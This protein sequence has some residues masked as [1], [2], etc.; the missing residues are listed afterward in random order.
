MGGGEKL[1]RKE[2]D[3]G[4]AKE[5]EKKCEAKVYDD[6]NDEV[7]RKLISIWNDYPIIVVLLCFYFLI[8]SHP[9]TFS[10]SLFIL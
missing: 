7:G 2:R 5:R 3:K 6:T 8:F 4:G 9:I 10:G 1:K